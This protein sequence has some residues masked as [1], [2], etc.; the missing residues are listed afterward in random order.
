[1]NKITIGVRR[2]EKSVHTPGPGT[3]S[4]DRADHQ[5]MIRSSA[6]DFSKQTDRQS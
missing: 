4:P 6:A 3:Y 5:T 1:M 2:G